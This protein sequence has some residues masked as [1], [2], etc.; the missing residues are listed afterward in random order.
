METGQGTGKTDEGEPLES[1]DLGPLVFSGSSEEDV[2]LA[3][4]FWVS[5]SMHPHPESRLVLSSTEQRLPVAQ[6]FRP[7]F[8]ERHFDFA[9]YK[10]EEYLEQE[11]KFREIEEKEKYIQKA[12]KREEILHL[13]RKQ[14]EERIEKERFSRLH[15]PKAKVPPIRIERTESEIMDEEEVRALNPE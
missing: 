4:Q 1:A 3:K 9:Y 13:L 12:K 7:P 10:T 15:K 2:A 8:V 14:R 5:A 6:T 11:R